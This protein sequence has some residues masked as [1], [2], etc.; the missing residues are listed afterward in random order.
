MSGSSEVK[1]FL[2]LA[3]AR[4]SQIRDLEQ[5]ERQRGW[6]EAA[7][8]EE[9]QKKYIEK[10]WRN[11]GVLGLFEGLRDEGVVRMEYDSKFD[12]TIPAEIKISEGECT[13]TFDKWVEDFRDD[14][15][16]NRYSVVKA[17]DR[18]GK[19]YINDKKVEKDLIGE[20]AAAIVK[21]KKYRQ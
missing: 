6:D 11:V 16:V 1:K 12:K 9:E 3:K 17:E 7:R 14:N 2:D 21:L 20:V 5:R 8:L 10:K 18:D 4:D 15:Y 19:L 13:L